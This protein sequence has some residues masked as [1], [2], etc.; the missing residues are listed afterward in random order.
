VVIESAAAAAAA[1]S[2]S[3][4]AVTTEAWADVAKHDTSVVAA[5]S[6]TDSY[7]RP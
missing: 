6:F 7:H 3:A 1:I 5:L 4:L 2:C